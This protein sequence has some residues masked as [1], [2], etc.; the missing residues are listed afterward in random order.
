MKFETLD[1]HSLVVWADLFSLYSKRMCH[2]SKARE[3]SRS[4]RND[5]VAEI[6]AEPSPF[7]T[8]VVCGRYVRH[9]DW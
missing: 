1:R 7:N 3:A 2:E 4:Q 9:F 8:T 6:T 5:L